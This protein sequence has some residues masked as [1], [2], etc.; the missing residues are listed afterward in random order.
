MLI[1]E[2]FHLLEMSKLRVVYYQGLLEKLQEEI[3]ESRDANKTKKKTKREKLERKM[4]HDHLVV[5]S[6][7]DLIEDYFSKRL[8]KFFQKN[9]N[10]ENGDK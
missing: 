4:I 2:V 1:S 6:T 9:D 5:E 3:K 10:G 8:D 7:T